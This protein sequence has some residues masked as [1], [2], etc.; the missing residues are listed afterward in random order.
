[1]SAQTLP[2]PAPAP[3]GWSACKGNHYEAEV[4]KGS[5]NMR[6]FSAKASDRYSKG[7]RLAHL[8]EQDGNTVMVW[9][10]NF[11]P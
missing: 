1:M 2:P 3:M 7:W 11:H 6:H 10:H 4:N 9:E 8:Y 5:I